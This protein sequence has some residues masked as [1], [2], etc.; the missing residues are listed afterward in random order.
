MPFKRLKENYSGGLD[1]ENFATSIIITTLMRIVGM[2]A[3]ATIIVGGLV[4]L[5]LFIVGGLI[6]FVVWLFLPLIIP[7]LIVTSLISIIK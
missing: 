7:A 6:G 5:T 2:F 3:R 1:L 4:I